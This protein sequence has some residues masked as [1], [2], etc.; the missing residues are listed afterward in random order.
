MIE[1]KISS[2]MPLP[3][4]CSVICSPSHMTKIAPTVSVMTVVNTNSK[5]GVLTAPGIACRNAAYP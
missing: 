4:P 5:P 3:M 1:K 2:D